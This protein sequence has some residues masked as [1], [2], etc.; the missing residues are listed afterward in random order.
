MSTPIVVTETNQVVSSSVLST[1]VITVLEPQVLLVTSESTTTVVNTEHEN[2]VQQL[3]QVAVVTSSTQG[4]QGPPGASD[5]YVYLVAAT[6]IGGNRAV[7]VNSSG[8]TYAG[9]T[10]TNILGISV[11][12]VD[13]G[14]LAQIQISGIITE[15]SW[16]W[17]PQ[18]PI[19]VSDSGILTQQVPETGSLFIVGYPVL[20]TQIFID[21]QAPILLG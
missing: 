11:S 1:E 17:L 19:F 15:P 2:I 18:T 21:K 16:N 6:A 4:P 5:N 20:S 12:A 8:L 10:S 7:A 3:E 9:T 13:A 14:Q